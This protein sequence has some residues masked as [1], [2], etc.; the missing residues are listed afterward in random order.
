MLNVTRTVLC[1]NNERNNIIIIGNL[2]AN[3][4]GFA[5]NANIPVNSRVNVILSNL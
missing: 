4:L 5:S 2:M 1:T 3:V